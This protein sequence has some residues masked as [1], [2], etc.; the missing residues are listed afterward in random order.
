MPNLDLHYL[1]SYADCFIVDE[2][3][4]LINECPSDIHTTL[5]LGVAETV[6]VNWN[7]PNASDNSGTPQISRSQSPNTQF[8]IGNTTVHYSFT[9]TWN[10]T[11]VC[12]FDV[13]VEAGEK[14]L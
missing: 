12:S 9:D 2:T 11:A 1:I 3:A 5:E 4:P 14:S 6:L 13:V 7:E 8:P 10:N